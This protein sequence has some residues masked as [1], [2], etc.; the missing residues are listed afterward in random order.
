MEIGRIFNF[1][2]S[3]N[4]NIFAE[5]IL[6]GSRAR[7][8]YGSD[9]DWDFLIL[10]NSP[11]TSEVEELIRNKIYDIELET[12][13]VITSIIEQKCCLLTFYHKVSG[14]REQTTRMPTHEASA[15]GESCQL[16]CWPKRELLRVANIDNKRQKGSP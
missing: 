14:R 12:E 3:I 5:T 10:L 7:G 8:D 15:A 16:P 1:Y 11:G 13:E 2:G 9:S 6:F 4:A